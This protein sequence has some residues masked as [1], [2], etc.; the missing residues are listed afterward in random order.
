M[1]G[2]NNTSSGSGKEITEVKVNASN[3]SYGEIISFFVFINY[4]D[5]TQ[6]KWSGNSSYIPTLG[7][8]FSTG[9]TLT[10]Q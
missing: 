4:A 9:A 8:L 10:K 1:V 7:D 2:K 6:E 5:G 3:Y